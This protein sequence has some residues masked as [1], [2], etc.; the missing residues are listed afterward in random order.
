MSCARRGVIGGKQASAQ[1]RNP[2][3][4]KIVRRNHAFPQDWR[5]LAWIPRMPLDVRRVRTHEPAQRQ[6]VRQRRVFHARQRSRPRN[7]TIVEIRARPKSSQNWLLGV[8]RAVTIDSVRKPGFTCESSHKLFTSKPAPIT[9]TTATAISAI[10]SALRKRLLFAA[11]EF[12]PPVFSDSVKSIFDA[13]SAGA[14]PKIAPVASA[15]SAVNASTRQSIVTLESR[16]VSAG[17]TAFSHESPVNAKSM[18]KGAAANREQNA[19]G[20]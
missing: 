10:A 3:D 20:Q 18:P 16:G 6:N 1:Q 9:S 19:L 11:P 5:G 2:H 4:A 8:I 14:S 17:K 13:C 7:Q 15:I 12:C